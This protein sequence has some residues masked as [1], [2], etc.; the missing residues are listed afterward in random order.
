MFILEVNMGIQ[1]IAYIN[2]G[3]NTFVKNKKL[4]RAFQTRNEA[5][6]YLERLEANGYIDTA[7]NEWKHIYGYVP[8][9]NIVVEECITDYIEAISEESKK[10]GKEELINHMLSKFNKI[11]YNQPK[12]LHMYRLKLE[13]YYPE[14]TWSIIEDIYEKAGWRTAS[15]HVN[16]FTCETYLTLYANE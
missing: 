10:V 16:G 1:N 6:E 12:G 7:C 5:E 13:G 14:F 4:A 2:E 9:F 8:F 3:N 15:I 11:L